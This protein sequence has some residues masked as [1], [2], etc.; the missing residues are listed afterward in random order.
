MTENEPHKKSQG[1]NQ[2]VLIRT[3][4]WFYE[5]ATPRVSE[6]TTALAVL[7]SHKKFNVI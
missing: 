6:R 7:I 4:C 5:A 1:E 2:P 3:F